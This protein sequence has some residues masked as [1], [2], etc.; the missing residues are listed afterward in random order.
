V[1]TVTNHRIDA[2]GGKLFAREWAPATVL[3]APPLVL[4]HDSL[5]CVRLWRDFP[6]QLANE[7]RRRVVAYDRLGFGQSDARSDHLTTR[8]LAEEATIYLPCVLRHLG[9]ERF[10]AFGHSV[11][12]GMALH[13]GA[14]LAA[15]CAAIVVESAQAFAEDRTLQSIA[16]ARIDFRDSTKL[17]KLYRHHGDK[18]QW[19][20]EAWT[21]T[22]LDPAFASWSL[23]TELP[24]V[25]CPILAIHGDQDEFGSLRHPELIRSLAGGP[26]TTRILEGVGHVPHREQPQ[27]II[28]VVTEFLQASHRV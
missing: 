25:R 23:K 2:P 18:M 6:A 4:L 11:G 12:G 28:S 14:A 19:V 27:T 5:G 22:W 13:C 16:A 26:V 20:L 7:S 8:F 21:E 15:S 17:A 10:V 1:S 9:I 3:P 24:Q